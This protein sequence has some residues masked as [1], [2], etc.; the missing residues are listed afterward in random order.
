MSR[1]IILGSV[2]KKKLIIAHRKRRRVLKNNER[3]AKAGSN[4]PG[5]VQD[6]GFTRPSVLILV[7]FR[8]FA[9]RWVAALTSHTPSPSYQVENHARFLTEYGLPPDAVDKL[10]EAAPGAYPRDHIEMFKGNV[11][12]SFRLGIKVTRKSVKL[13]SEFYS[14]DVIVAS[15]LG[16]RIS[17][18]KD[19]YATWICCFPPLSH[20]CRN[21]DF[22][23]SIEVV[24]A[25]QLDAMT[26]QNWDHVQ[27]VFSNLNQMPKDS[28]DADFSRIKPWVLD[29]KYVRTGLPSPSILT[30]IQAVHSSVR[31]SCLR[32]TRP[33]RPGHCSINRSRMLLERSVPSA[34]GH[35]SKSLKE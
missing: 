30:S 17:I 9:Q 19:K 27:F 20:L 33:P 5:D 28:H 15:P 16:L 10:V 8:S 12:D 6:Q 7:P 13:F 1:D 3:L 29:G 4:P 24:I 21:A 23:S 25:D 26:M 35:R 31:P 22:L 2:A 32:L 34:F 14:C 18:E 11:D